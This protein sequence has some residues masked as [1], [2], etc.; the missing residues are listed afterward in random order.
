MDENLEL[1]THIYETA[2]MGSYTI[3]TLINKLKDKENKIKFCLEKEIKEYEKYLNQA[4]KLLEKNGITPK[5]A[6]FMAKIGSN[7]GIMKETMKDNSDSA[8]AQMVVEGITMGVTIISA[9]INS[10]RKIADKSTIKL[11]KKFLEFQEDEIEKL[12]SFM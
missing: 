5:K 10:Y 6:S 9:K 3:T 11:A 12:K 8:I 4:G 2:E 1:L 7:M